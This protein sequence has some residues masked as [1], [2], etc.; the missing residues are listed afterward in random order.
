MSC[1]NFVS[2]NSQLSASWIFF[3]AFSLRMLSLWWVFLF[4]VLL[5]LEIPRSTDYDSLMELGRSP[6]FANLISVSQEL[7]QISKFLW[8]QLFRSVTSGPFEAQVVSRTILVSTFIDNFHD[9]RILKKIFNEFDNSLPRLLEICNCFRFVFIVIGEEDCM[10]SFFFFFF[11]CHQSSVCNRILISCLIRM[12]DS[13]SFLCV[14]PSFVCTLLS[15]VPSIWYS[16]CVMNHH[17]MPLV[18]KK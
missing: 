18:S 11:F 2:C 4:A 13:V 14:S 17:V 15:C 12:V 16:I 8:P 7:H 3:A 9:V 6:T 10:I 5:V 1:L